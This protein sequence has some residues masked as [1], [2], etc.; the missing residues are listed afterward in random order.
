VV[1][2]VCRIGCVQLAGLHHWAIVCRKLNRDCG[3]AC[4]GVYG[5]R[6][7]EIGGQDDS[8]HCTDGSALIVLGN[9]GDYCRSRIVLVTFH[10]DG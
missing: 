1:K 4:W 3:P 2:L 8:C 5:N 6:W 9:A 10:P 7:R